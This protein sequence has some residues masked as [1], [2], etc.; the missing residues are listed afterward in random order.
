[1]P[2]QPDFI[3]VGSTRFDCGHCGYS[4]LDRVYWYPDTDHEGHWLACPECGYDEVD[5]DCAIHDVE[6]Y[7]QRY[8]A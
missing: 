8:S 1:M 2:E 6:W 7:Q 3:E 5:P 4:F